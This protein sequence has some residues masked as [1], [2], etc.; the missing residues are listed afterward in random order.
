MITIYTP[1]YNRAYILP[2]LYESLQNQTCRDFEWIIIDDGSTDETESVV[3]NWI[4]T[5]K[6]DVVYKKKKNGGMCSAMNVAVQMARY[7]W[8]IK[9][10]S[11]DFLTSNAVEKIHEWVETITDDD[12]FVG[13]S[14]LRGYIT[15]DKIIGGYPS[16][17]KYKHYIDATNL[18][19]NKFN[20]HGDK[21]EVYKTEILRKYPFPE[22]E[23]ENVLDPAVVWDAIA[24]DGYKIRWFNYVIYK[25]EY[26]DDGLTKRYRLDA[27]RCFEGF[28][29]A[30]KKELTHH[31]S[32]AEKS[33]SIVK[34]FYI[35][36]KKG[37]GFTEAK[38]KINVSMI[39]IIAAFFI[40][41][42][43]YPKKVISSLI[44][45]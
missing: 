37:L 3:K 18:Q 23:G 21:A 8:S 4:G 32:Y 39:R 13:V 10:D 1:T 45:K 26:I 12:S 42:F 43:C 11:D 22:F 35:A 44:K 34:Y 24:N 38:N 16:N 14:G 27:A 29:F 7:E 19:R 15:N 33:S 6:F 30:I 40:V 5:N 2:K 28:T 31:R 41:M 20:L 9:V 36:R 25:C 17:K